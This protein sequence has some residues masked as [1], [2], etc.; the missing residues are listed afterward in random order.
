MPLATPDLS[1][2]AKTQ[3][4]SV[5]CPVID[6]DQFHHAAVAGRQRPGDGIGPVP[7]LDDHPPDMLAGLR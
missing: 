3:T 5:R 2:H 7:E 1:L 6:H 4:R